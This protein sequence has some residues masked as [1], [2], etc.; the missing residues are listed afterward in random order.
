VFS[1][2]LA[3]GLDVDA[4]EASGRLRPDGDPHD[5]DIF[6]MPWLPSSRGLGL[7]AKKRVAKVSLDGGVEVVHWAGA[8]FPGF[9]LPR[10]N[11]GGPTMAQGAVAAR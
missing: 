2:L 3:G 1:D 6:A 5:A 7:L 9:Q 8:R 10:L 11:P 4:A